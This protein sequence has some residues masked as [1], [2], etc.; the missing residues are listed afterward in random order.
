M[1]GHAPSGCKAAGSVN[2]L[3]QSA[4]PKMQSVEPSAVA[5]LNGAG[6]ACIM[7]QRRFPQ[8]SLKPEM[9]LSW[10]VHHLS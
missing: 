5:D 7:R 8:K 3:R 1:I 6:T 2:A 9:G 10:K 4:A